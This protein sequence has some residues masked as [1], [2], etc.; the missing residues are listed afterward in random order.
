M[1]AIDSIKLDSA[2]ARFKFDDSTNTL[3]IQKKF[4]NS[5]T[6][7]TGTMTLDKIYIIYNGTEKATIINP[8]STAGVTI[9]IRLM[10]WGSCPNPT[11][12]FFETKTIKESQNRD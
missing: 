8:Y 4:I 9:M 3:N 12:L 5:I 2:Y 7:M 1:T 11:T 6:F 10:Q